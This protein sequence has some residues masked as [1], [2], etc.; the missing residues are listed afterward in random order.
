M[1]VLVFAV[2][3]ELFPPHQYG[4][5][6]EPYS[7]NI[8]VPAVYKFISARPSIDDIV[9]LRADKDY[10]GAQIPIARA[11]DVLWAGYDNRNTF[12]GYSGYEPP[13]Y[14]PTYADFVDFHADDVPKLK[15]LGL[16]YVLVDKQLSSS[17][18]TLLNDIAGALHT[19]VY[20]DKR[21]A[22]FKV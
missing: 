3:F 2:A 21:Y 4:I 13:S 10:P 16:R 5:S 20:E 7:R 8:S 12:N 17:R 14:A 11:E 9:V 18:P 15:K 6:V 1:F 19:K 22:L